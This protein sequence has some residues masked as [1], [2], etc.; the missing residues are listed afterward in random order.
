MENAEAMFPD[1]TLDL[2]LPIHGLVTTVP[3]SRVS[4]ENSGISSNNR[5]DVACRTS[6]ACVLL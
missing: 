2:K 5:Y 1:M 3:E 6:A 4:Y